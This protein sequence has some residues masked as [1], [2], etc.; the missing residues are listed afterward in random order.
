MLIIIGLKPLPRTAH[1]KVDFIGAGVLIAA[2]CC[3]LLVL[4]WGGSTYPLGVAADRG[5]R[6][7]GG[8]VWGLLAIVERFA[9]EPILAPRLFANRVFVLAVLVIAF[10]A[11]GMFG[12]LVFMPLFFQLVLGASP[13]MAGLMIAPMM[14][15]VIVSS[16]VGGRLVSI[17][18][19]YKLLVVLGMA[20]ATLAFLV[21][22]WAAATG[23]AIAVIECALVVL[24][25]GIALANPNLTTA[26][27][28][29]VTRADLGAATSASAFFRSLGGA[30]GV[31]LAGGILTLRLNAL[32]PTA[33]AAEFQDPALRCGQRVAPG[34]SRARADRVSLQPRLGVNLPGGRRNRGG[35]IRDRAAAS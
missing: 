4:S 33:V 26:I 16:F 11:I 17:T 21:L 23:A 3:T 13:A 14:G 22:A 5:S 18:G 9:A 25:V 8:P 27:Q 31:A 10:A 30:L 19:R 28:N 15:G 2:T 32:L 7:G 29:A 34:R 35:C 24:G 12:A 6:R 1:H 20:A